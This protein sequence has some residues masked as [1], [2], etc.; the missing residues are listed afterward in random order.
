M[1]SSRFN[2]DTCTAVALLIDSVNVHEP[3][4]AAFCFILCFLMGV[5]GGGSTYYGTLLHHNAVEL[6]TLAK[7][8]LIS[9]VSFGFDHWTGHET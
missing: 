2:P 4:A 5:G 3:D 9:L 1:A 8:H 6:E 7:D